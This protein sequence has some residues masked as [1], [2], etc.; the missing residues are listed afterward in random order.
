MLLY[1]LILLNKPEK[2][3]VLKKTL[4]LLDPTGAWVEYYDGD[5]PHNCRARPWESAMNIEGVIAYIEK[6]YS[7]T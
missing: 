4:S 2:E 1:N 7:A 6:E 5:S 3:A